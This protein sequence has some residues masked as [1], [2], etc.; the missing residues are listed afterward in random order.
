MEGSQGNAVSTIAFKSHAGSSVGIGVGGGQDYMWEANIVVL[1]KDDS[2]LG[3][4]RGW[5][6]IGRG[7]AIWK[8]KK[9]ELTKFNKGFYEEHSERK[10]E[11]LLIPG[12]LPWAVKFLEVSLAENK[13]KQED[14]VC[15]K[16]FISF[17][18]NKFDGLM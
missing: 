7:R 8:H 2:D 15:G 11:L 4:G 3:H 6:G 10:E 9:V 18:H 13:D 12:F 14:Q 16:R 1:L 17:G 5:W